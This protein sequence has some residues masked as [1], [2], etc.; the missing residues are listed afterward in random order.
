ML[1]KSKSAKILD[2]LNKF[3]IFGWKI[4]LYRS[5]YGAI[6]GQGKWCASLSNTVVVLFLVECLARIYLPAIMCKTGTLWRAACMLHQ[7]HKMNM[8]PTP[9]KRR[10]HD[11]LERWHPSHP[12]TLIGH[13][14]E[15][16][17]M[18]REHSYPFYKITI[19][20]LTKIQPFSHTVGQ[21]PQFTKNLMFEK[22][23][24]LWKIGLWKCEF[25]EQ[26]DFEIVNFVTK[27]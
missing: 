5:V 12:F 16:K 26:W 21:K 10:H 8:H 3:N 14:R 2:F 6:I 17:N 19:Q 1:Q 18:N 25:C 24:I 27:W 13:I 4:G 15:G 9:V 23:R 11:T 22:M 20:D 7:S